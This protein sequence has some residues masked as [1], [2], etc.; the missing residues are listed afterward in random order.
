MTVRCVSLAWRAEGLLAEVVARAFARVDFAA[1]AAFDGWRRLFA[2]AAVLAFL[3]VRRPVAALRAPLVL[4]ARAAFTVLRVRAAA[5]LFVRAVRL[6]P[7]VRALDFA[8]V[9]PVFL[10][11]A[12]L[13]LAIAVVLSAAGLP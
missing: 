8:R 4:R 5:E 12:R 10:V 6:L 7:T 13:R 2:R 9:E 3:L 11:A 1:L